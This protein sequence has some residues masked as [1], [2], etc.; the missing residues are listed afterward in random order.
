MTMEYLAVV[1]RSLLAVLFLASAVGKLRSR[2]AYARFTAATARLAPGGP[3]ARRVAAAVVAAELAV[4]PLVAFP[5]T[6]L[7]GFGLALALLTGFTLAI[8][9]ALRRNDRAPCACFG[10]AH[11]R[12]GYGQVLRNLILLAC[13][14]LGAVAAAVA[15]PPGDPAGVLLAVGGGAVAA[16]LVAFADDI[17]DLFR[18]IG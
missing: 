5:G 14:V 10:G 7:L 8:L 1:C 16:L 11:G 9:A 12:L 6:V 3:P 4:V 15:D 2:A 17:V 18:P 13:A